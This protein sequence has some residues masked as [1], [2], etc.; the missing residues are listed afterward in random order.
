M[1]RRHL[2]DLLGG[3]MEGG[4]LVVAPGAGGDPLLAAWREAA[5]EARRAYAA[6]RAS[7]RGD[8]FAVYRACAARADAAQDALAA[9]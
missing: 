2:E 9:R 4:V 8:D 3:L 1:S 6:W 7:H 5:A